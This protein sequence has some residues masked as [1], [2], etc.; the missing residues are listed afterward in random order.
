M[1]KNIV[2]CKDSC[3]QKTPENTG[4]YRNKKHQ[5]LKGSLQNLSFKISMETIIHLSRIC[6]Q[7][8]KSSLKDERALFV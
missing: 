8:I 6:I 5:Y 7:S 4:N 3:I 2:F 1:V